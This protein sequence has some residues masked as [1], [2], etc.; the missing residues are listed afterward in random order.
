[1][2]PLPSASLQSFAGTHIRGTVH[3]TSV[4]HMILTASGGKHAVTNETK[5]DKRLSPNA[6]QD[7]YSMQPLLL[8]RAHSPSPTCLHHRQSL[9]LLLLLL[10]LS[11]LSLWIWREQQGVVVAAVAARHCQRIAEGGLQ[12]LRLW[13]IT[14]W[15]W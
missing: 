6:P 1:M 12:R 8:S 9:L 4:L 2:P 13:M 5:R 15:M 10:L 7:E 14:R 11:R 3:T